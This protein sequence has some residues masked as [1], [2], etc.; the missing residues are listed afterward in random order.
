MRVTGEPVFDFIVIGGG[1]AGCLLANRL[2]ES[3]RHSVCLIEAGP[4]DLHPFIHLPAGY[5][6]TLFNPAYT[7]RFRTEPSV[8]TAGRRIETTQGRTLGGSSSINGLVY[9]R[10]QARDFDQWAQMGN[11]GWSHADVLPFFRQTECRIGV[12][13]DR[14]RGR[15][16]QLPVSDLDWH[17]PLVTAFVK[18][19]QTLGI[20]V[21]PDYN[22]AE[23]AGVGLYQRVILGGRRHSSAV[24]FLAPA[25]RRANLM[26]RTRTLVARILFDQGRACGVVCR[27]PDGFDDRILARREV[28]VAAGAINSPKLLQISGIGAPGHLCD[29]G[30]PVVHPL[31]G[32][33]ENLRDHWAVRC[34]ARVRGQVTINRLVTGMRLLDQAARWVTGR[35]GILSVSPSL[36]HVFWKSV[37][38][39]DTPDLQLTFTPASYREGVAGLLDRFDGM[40]CGVWQQRP[41]S[42]GHVR[43]RT[44]QAQDDPVVQ[45]N[46]LS[47]EIDRA[48]LIRGMR[49][50][51]RLLGSE[52]L[53]P[54]FDGAISPD[55][56]LRRDDE[57]LDFARRMGSTVFHL[58]GTCRMGPPDD[59]MA[60][61]DPQLRVRGIRGLRVIDSSVMPTMPSANTMAA[62]YMIAEKGAH[63]VL[64]AARPG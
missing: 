18:G 24:S 46:Y 9:N 1:T 47:A 22:G 41:E 35:P 12:G 39:M 2:T 56:T 31:P 60:V 19:A 3:G 25:R 63:M 55:D 29:L 59:R 45:P 7:W 10:G 34:V 43:A 64:E 26:V 54:W 53:K 52:P 38:D 42:T 20:P 21:N 49:L 30:V 4:R 62:T 32:V 44:A 5:I 61:V 16:G 14:F 57:L 27:G 33:G 37:P 51:R 13:D 36:A 11:T 8:G 28:I 40:T 6:R 17:H 50:A 15:E 23:Q 58:I 48:T